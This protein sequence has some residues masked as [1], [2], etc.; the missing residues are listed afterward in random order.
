MRLIDADKYKKEIMDIMACWNI[1][2]CL[3]DEDRREA[4][5][6]LK[7]ALNVIDEMRTAFDFDKVFRKLKE[8]SEDDSCGGVG[9]IWAE[10]VID[11]IKSELEGRK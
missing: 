4:V 10:D 6:N 8:K 2:P 5:K 11:I 7:T 3:S 1:S 9:G